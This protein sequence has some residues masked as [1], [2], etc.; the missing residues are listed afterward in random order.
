MDPDKS[1]EP[2][3]F[4]IHYYKTFWNLIK[5]DLLKML[6]GTCK[7]DKIGGGTNS[8]FLALIPKDHKLEIFSIFRPISLCNDSYKI[9]TKI[10]ANRLKH[11]MNKDYFDKSR[12]LHSGKKHSR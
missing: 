10:I 2:E 6:N 5:Y 4:T 12:R 8:S 1:L 7:K 3:G 11:I 9:L